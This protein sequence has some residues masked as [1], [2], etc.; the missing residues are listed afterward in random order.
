[1]CKD[2]KMLI[3]NKDDEIN[4]PDHI[5]AAYDPIKL[6]R[7]NARM[8]MAKPSYG[9]NPSP[10]FIGY[11]EFFKEFI[12]YSSSPVFHQCLKDALTH[13]IDIVSLIHRNRSNNKKSLLN[14]FFFIDKDSP[15]NT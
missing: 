12:D 8:S 6:K 11:E 4:G 2:D 3:D 5:K 13:E 7:L 14:S 9:P 15:R 1:M 10:K